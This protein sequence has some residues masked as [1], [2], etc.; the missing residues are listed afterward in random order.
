M[1]RKCVLDMSAASWRYLSDILE[2]E[3]FESIKHGD[4]EYTVITVVRNASAEFE[5]GKDTATANAEATTVV[6]YDAH[7]EVR[8]VVKC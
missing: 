7:L 3:T 6:E 5:S 4:V 8:C 2:S 1:N